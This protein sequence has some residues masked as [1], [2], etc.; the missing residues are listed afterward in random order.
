MNTTFSDD[1]RKRGHKYHVDRLKAPTGVGDAVFE[2]E[3]GSFD[4]N[5]ASQ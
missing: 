5:Y 3:A 4:S 1:I 2:V